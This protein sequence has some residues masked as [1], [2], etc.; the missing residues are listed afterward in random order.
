MPTIGLCM[1]VKDEARVIARCIESARRLIDFVLI[2]DTG[3]TDGTQDAIRACLRETGLP[4][5]VI[6]EPW[7]DFATNRSSALTRL[8]AHKNI[9]YALINDADDQIIFDEE[10]DA[11]AFK[12]RMT[13][14]LYD[15]EIRH[16]NIKYHRPQ[17]LRNRLPFCYRGVLH[18]FVQSPPGG[19]SR[20][21][22]IG[23]HVRYGGDG[24]R[25]QDPQKF[26]RDAALLERALETEQDAFLIAR[27]TFYLGQSYRDAGEPER[28]L[29][30]YL[31]RPALGFWDQEIFVS[32]LNAARLKEQ[33]GH[34]EQE[35]LDAYRRASDA[36]PARAEALHGASRFCRHKSRY[37]EGTH[38]ARQGLARPLPPGLFVEPWI[39]EHGLLDELAV[40]AYWAERYAESLEACERLLRNDHLPADLRARV[41]QNAEHAAAK[42][43]LRP[44]TVPAA[45]AVTVVLIRP[46][47]Y[48]HSGAFQDLADSVIAGLQRAGH[49]VRTA[50]GLAGL[51][52]RGIVFG[53]H[54]AAPEAL[55]HLPAAM[56]VYNTEH[57][58]SGFMTDA[59]QALLRRQPVWDFNA[60]N[61]ADLHERLGKPV[62]HVPAGYVP[63]LARIAPTAV[64]DIDV[65]FYGSMSARR[66]LILDQLSA[67]GLVVETVFGLYGAARDA[68]IARAKLVLNVHLYEP[69]RFEVLRVSY[70]LA[71]G[72]AV[73]TECNDGETIDPD[74]AAGLEAVPYESLVTSVQALVRDEPRRR[75][76]AQAGHAAFVARDEAAIL[77]R[78]MAA[79]W[80][81]A[82]PTLPTR[83]T[84]GGFTNWRDDALNLDIDPAAQPDIV[85]DIADPGLLAAA[86]A[87]TRFGSLRLPRGGFTTLTAM[88][89][90]ERVRDLATAMTNCLDLLAEGGQLHI[91]V[92][93]DL[94]YGAWQDPANVRAFNERSWWCYCDGYWQIGWTV[95]RFDLVELSFVFSRIGQDLRAGGMAEQEILR[96]PR[97]VDAM[98]VVLRKRTLTEPER[99][100]GTARRSA[101]RAAQTSNETPTA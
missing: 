38:L 56:V 96:T 10:F 74:L 48:A 11:A 82:A 72:R 80:G 41:A 33:L 34:P 86:F 42:L 35:V 85:A 83:M 91:A 21:T 94:S 66:R 52:G 67:A 16:G 30:A 28:A 65:L 61:A 36:V 44:T 2:V 53:A 15:V 71:N 77:R 84:L 37:Q 87:S 57:T 40:N 43:A 26:V 63:Q 39:Y 5:E 62:L 54:L 9:D 20:E 7:Q 12:A 98:R 22:A 13:T 99:A 70:L 76:L 14:D 25:S 97:A 100:Q 46:A 95:A 60:D 50:D 73:V 75:A 51:A 29:A 93:Y 90:L 64:Q 17:I 32:L 59:Y 68:L 8:R 88:H 49:E 31:R 69:G 6:D 47:H 89:V 55:E 78:A 24:A 45:D 101:P 18:E 19:H 3:S 58:A 1:I 81:E 23:F 92:P 27:Y 4:G 79:T